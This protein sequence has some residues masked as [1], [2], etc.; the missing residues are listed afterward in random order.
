[1]S[2]NAESHFSQVPHV[3]IQR[4]KFVVDYDHKATGN[5]GE[6][7]PIFCE[8]VL[9]GDTKIPTMGELLRMTTPIH[10]TMDT[11]F[12]DTY[13]FFVPNRLLWEHWKEFMGENT[14]TAWEQ[15]TEYTIPQT[16]APSGGWEL[17]TIAD[18][19]G[20]PTKIGNISVSSLPFRAYCLIWNEWFRDQNLKD[21]CM[22]N[23]DDA[24]TKGLNSG[25]YITAAQCGA[26]PLRAAKVHDYF[27]SA[28]PQPQKGEPVQVPIGSGNIPVMT[29][30]SNTVTG[31][32]QA[33]KWLETDGTNPTTKYITVQKDGKTT[34]N[35]D[36]DGYDPNASN[37][38]IYPSNLYV[39]LD[40]VNAISINALRQAF[41]IQ[42]LKERDARGGTRYREIL[43]AHFGVSSPDSRQQIPEYLGGCR[44]YINISQVIQTSQ[45]TESSPQGNTAAYSSTS[46]TDT[47]FTKSFTEHGYVIGVAVIRTAQTYQQGINRMWSRKSKYD[48]Y[49]PA[50]ANIGEQAILNK[51]IY[52]Q[53]TPEDEEV[54][55]YQ[56]PWAEYRYHPSEITGLFRSNATGTLDS[57]HYA[58]K[59]DELP[60][61]SSEWID[62]G[63]AEMYRTLAVQNQPQFIMDIHYK[64][65]NV[66][67]MP[68][69][70]VPGLLDHH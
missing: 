45:T 54:F 47:P 9:P 29:G 61:L 2:R 51:E 3:E 31:R 30:A 13:F 33:L 6:L 25:D 5:A 35:Q 10:P 66:R 59:Y 15:K 19:F 26:K 17:G 69:F 21:P 22:V 20:L 55:G 48:F 64:V 23:L 37:T 4:S 52:A 7:I 12:Q 34:V 70:G 42:R 38:Y 8:E 36:R 49:W 63:D 44:R 67:P 18:N 58:Q 53:G 41:A 32:Q 57:W 1:M 40:N 50:L 46:I 43:K 28:L 24:E 56:E 39:S 65:T 14:Q 62:Q 11:C 27:T 16:T 68:V 60:K